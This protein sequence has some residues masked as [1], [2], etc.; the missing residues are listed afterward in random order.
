MDK[1]LKMR[2]AIL[3]ELA[4][5]FKILGESFMLCIVSLFNYFTRLQNFGFSR[6]GR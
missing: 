4:V 3:G 6:S 5:E 2:N 1:V